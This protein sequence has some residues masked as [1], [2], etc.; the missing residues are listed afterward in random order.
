MLQSC[1]IVAVDFEHKSEAQVNLIGPLKVWAHVQQ[2]LEC[3]YRPVSREKN[4]KKMDQ[5]MTVLS[6]Y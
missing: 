5:Q 3:S 1:L 4:M 2:L 6:R